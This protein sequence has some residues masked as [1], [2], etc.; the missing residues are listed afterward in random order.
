M[1]IL[2]ISEGHNCT[3]AILVDGKIIACSSEER[4]SRLK[5]DSGYPKLAI[6][7]CLRQANIDPRDLDLVALSGTD[8]QLWWNGMRNEALFS[9]SD[10]VYEQHNYYKKILI[11]GESNKDVMPQYINDILKR[12]GESNK[13]YDFSGVE[14]EDLLN[15]DVNQKIRKKAV[16][17]HLGV[18]EEKIKFIDHHDCHAFFTYFSSPLREKNV[19]I[20]TMDSSGDRGVNATL[21]ITE[22]KGIKKI[23]E[24]TN[25]QWGRIYKYTTL[26]LGMKLHEHEYKVM[27]LAPYASISEVN[28]SYPIFNEILKVNGLEFE[29]GKK[30]KD[31]YF[32]FRDRLEGH[33]F[34]GI[35]GALQRKFEESVCEW[36]GNALKLTGAKNLVFGGGSA[37]NI[38]MNL[39][40][41]KL[42]NLEK[43]FIGPSPADESNALGACFFAYYQYLQEKG[44]DYQDI[45][46]LND[47]YLGSEFDYE[48]FLEIIKGK[49]EEYEIISNVVD[50]D[51]A[52]LLKEGKIIARAIG[53]MEFGARA[54]GN[55]SILADASNTDV[56]KKINKLIKHR[57]FWMPFACSV[58]EER[59]NDYL[60]N[61]KNLQSDYMTIG[62]ETK[63]LAHKHLIAGLHPEDLT[64]RP[65]IIRKEQNFEYHNLMNEFNKLTGIGGLL[66]TSLNLHGHPVVCSPEDLLMV[67]DNSDLQY[68]YIKGHLVQ[69]KN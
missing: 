1:K 56:V 64:A 60:V 68:V 7:F 69:K 54:L 16:I 8:T 10:H 40:I 29:W 15:T 51:V 62:F 14:L 24:T 18:K 31:L 5:N 26:L 17:N 38:K 37:M 45:Q 9:V 55:R 50:K 39:A 34:D 11:D 4:F 57:D 22:E 42:P 3:A 28:K 53:R 66:N 35:A 65:Q 21:S 30:P 47:A 52:Q 19:L 2:G 33:R 12:K 6:D 23:F 46:P 41:T 13:Y 48:N 32:H 27:G 49:G 59:A 61:G 36:V 25:C 43:I 44:L 63:E 20:A 67:L 58:L